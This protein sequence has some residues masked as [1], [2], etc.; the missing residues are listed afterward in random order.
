VQAPAEVCVMFARLVERTGM[1]RRIELYLSERVSGPMAMGVVRSV[2]LLPVSA[3]IHLTP[4]QLEV[5]LAHELAHIRR[6]DYMWNIVQTVVETLFFFHPAVW[7]VSASLRQQRELCCDDA[8]L[9]CCSD[10]VVYATALLSLEEQR[11][12]KLRFAMALD[13]NRSSLKSRIFRILG[14]APERRVEVAPLSLI[15]V[16]AMVTLFLLP[17]PRSFADHIV[18]AS[19]PIREAIVTAPQP[20]HIDA[21][22]VTAPE[23]R[24]PARA[25]QPKPM[26]RVE[27]HSPLSV[28]AKEH[29]DLKPAVVTEIS[30]V[31]TSPH[32]VAMQAIGQS[33]N[34]S[35]QGDYI[36]E[37]RA[38]G[39]GDDLDKLIEMKIQG[40]TPDYARSMQQLGFGKPT[41]QELISLKIFGVTPETVQSM[42]AAGLAPGKLQD[43][44]SYKIFKV[45]PEFVAGMK[46]AGFS[47]IPPSKLV[48]LRVHG[49]TPETAR[50]TKQQFPDVTLD[51]LVQLRVF[52]IDENFIA[53]AK[54][55]GFNSLTIDKLVKL[56]ISG[57]LDDGTQKEE[58]K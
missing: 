9:A 37:M 20:T 27:P 43:L 56:R 26:A 32:A 54:Q 19:Q 23:D 44:I 48:E 2:V 3:L 12:A 5:V 39:Y 41:A 40:I 17:L 10:P 24:R 4:E 35:G 28:E 30:Q 36:T 6:G 29:L 13:G 14:E 33:Q 42:K 45:T 15:G 8:A 51:Q 31:R 58:K 25:L 46:A 22:D 21:A 55:H 34:T 7:W 49:I 50:A 16:C 47:D 1:R 53:S 57:L 11:S 52:H 38:A 18:K